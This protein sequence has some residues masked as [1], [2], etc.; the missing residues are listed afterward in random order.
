MQLRAEP[1]LIDRANKTSKK[2]NN[3]LFIIV[4]LFKQKIIS[5]P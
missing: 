1:E 3:D 4:N 5:Y 2:Y